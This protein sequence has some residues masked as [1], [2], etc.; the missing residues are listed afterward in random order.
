[1]LGGGDNDHSTIK[2]VQKGEMTSRRHIRREKDGET[3]KRKLLPVLSCR[4]SRRCIKKTKNSTD[5][6]IQKNREIVDLEKFGIYS[7]LKFKRRICKDDNME[8]PTSG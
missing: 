4:R 1:M 8:Q 3:R 6:E 2:E 7:K 5:E